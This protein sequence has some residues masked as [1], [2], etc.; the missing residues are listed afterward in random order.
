M[1]NKIITNFSFKNVI[2]EYFEMRNNIK[3]CLLASCNGSMGT[4]KCGSPTCA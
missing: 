3:A 4:A 2:Y 1:M